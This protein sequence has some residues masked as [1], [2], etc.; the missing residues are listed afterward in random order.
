MNLV[1]SDQTLLGDD[2]TPAVVLG[3]GPIPASVARG[4]VCEAVERRAVTGHAAAAVSPSQERVRWWRWSRG[5]GFSRAGW[6]A[7]IGLRD[8]TCRTPYCDAPIRHRDHADPRN[9]GG[10]TSAV[11]GLGT[12]RARATT[13]KKHRAGRHAR[14]MKT[15]CTQPNSSPPPVRTTDRTAPPPPGPPVIAVS[16]IE[17]RIGIATGRPT[18]R[19]AAQSISPLGPADAVLQPQFQRAGA[20]VV[21]EIAA[22]ADP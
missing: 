3:Y 8:Q 1:M 2:N 6:R 13:P 15:V 5:R 14:Q 20:Q 9:R 11:N 10:P 17:A 12:V 21:L 4:L 18:R 19:L 16:E 7:F 22:C